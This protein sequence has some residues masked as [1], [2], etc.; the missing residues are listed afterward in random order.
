MN[1]I[2]NLKNAV[3]RYAVALLLLG[4]VLFSA[5]S[6]KDDSTTTTD[7]SKQYVLV[8]ENGAQA[9]KAG[10]SITYN[11]Y[12]I[13]KT[14][15][16]LSSGY[17]VTYA[18]DDTSASFNGSVLKAKDNVGIS[19]T[20]TATTTY[21]SVSYTAKVPVK[22]T[23]TAGENAPFA[24]SP[25]AVVWTTGAGTI[26]LWPIYLGTSPATFTYT[27]SNPAVITVNSAG[28][29]SFVSAGSANVTVSATI[30]GKL[31][32]VV[33]PVL[34]VAQPS[35]PLPVT[36]IQIDK[37]SLTLFKGSSKTF[38]VKAYNSNNEDVTNTVSFTWKFVPKDTSADDTPPFTVSAGSGVGSASATCTVKGANFDDGY[39]VVT[40]SGLTDQAE[41][42]VVNDKFVFCN[43]F[44]ITMGSMQIPG[45]SSDSVSTAQ[46]YKIDTAAFYAA[47]NNQQAIANSIQQLSGG[48]YTW[49]KLKTGIPQIDATL[50]VFNLR[51]NGN[52]GTF[53]AKFGAFGNGFA[54]VTNSI[55]P[56][57]DPGIVSVISLP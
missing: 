44:F 56:D 33:V 18:I 17:T 13:D 6:K 39:L 26:P 20:V 11:S 49:T 12:L 32:T 15:N 10:K 38:T 21:N 9:L 35:V 57:A 23:S 4:T 19:G 42:D 8:I 7:A 5:C 31:T 46:L 24:V 22:F 52:R 47:G 37:K 16:K 30:N 54:V 40:G 48:T 51:P 43:P 36:R 53:S 14:G 34:V 25:E 55:A 50:D 28:E 29:I 27:S 45:T 41:V 1:K 2:P 3:S